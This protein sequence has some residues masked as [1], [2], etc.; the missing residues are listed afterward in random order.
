M[1]V[2]GTYKMWGTYVRSKNDNNHWMYY[3]NQSGGTAVYPNF[4][5][6]L[7]A[8]TVLNWYTYKFD[9]NNVYR[10]GTKLTWTGTPGTIND[11]PL[12]QRSLF[13]FAVND[14][15]PIVKTS[16]L[17]M[18]Y[19]KIFDKNEKLL[20]DLIPVKNN[21]VGCMFDIVHK[22]FYENAGTEDFVCGPTK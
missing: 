20:F 18:E 15:D 3:Y 22:Q 11:T 21:G 16:V 19:F 7:S 10:N 9:R 1:N 2:S 5:P 17:Q 14:R 12:T 6:A 13:I 4:S 8:T